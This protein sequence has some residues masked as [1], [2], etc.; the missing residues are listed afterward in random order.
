[1][2]RDAMKAWI[3]YCLDDQIPIPEPEEE[4][5]DEYSGKFLVRITPTLHRKLAQGA[6]KN[7]VSMNHY[8]SELLS[9]RCSIIENYEKLYSQLVTA[10]TH[11]KPALGE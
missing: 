1:M 11:C 3:E 10:I 7:G 9:E 5:L 8:T 4:K 6:K 2:I